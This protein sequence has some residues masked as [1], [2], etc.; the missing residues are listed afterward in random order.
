MSLM[1]PIRAHAARALGWLIV[2]V[3]LTVFCG[4]PGQGWANEKTGPRQI[5][6]FI[7]IAL[8][9]DGQTYK[10]TRQIVHNAIDKAA[11]QNARLTLI[12]QFDVPKGEKNFGRG[13][14]FG[15]AHDLADF[16]S[17]DELNGV[18][19]VAYLPQSIEGH[20][21]LVAIACQ[22][23]MMAPDATIGAAGI[24]EST[25]GATLR[26]AYTEVA[27]RRRTVPA[28][29]ALG[30]LDPAIEVLQVDT[31][32][33]SE[34]VTPEGLEKVQKEHATKEPIVI[35]RAGEQAEFS[36]SE[37][38][39][40]GIARYLASDRQSVA[41]ALELPLTAIG[42]DPSLEGGWRA[43][44]VD[45]KGPIRAES[46]GQV[47]RM[48]EKQVR[49]NGVNFIC[50]WIDSPGGPVDE[51]MNLA[52]F[53]A[54]QLDPAK[55]RTVAYVPREALSDA[56]IIAMSCDQLVMSPNAILGG[57]GAHELSADEVS[58]VRQVI[59]NRLAKHKGRSWSLVAAMIDPHLDVFRANRLGDIE[60]F[61][62]TELK[63]QADSA[64]WNRGGASDYA[65]RPAE[66]DRHACGRVRLGKSSC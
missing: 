18:R 23:I 66:V 33:G 56:A 16:L 64:K 47:E 27:N 14:E 25:I 8:P 65:R 37:A 41:K 48:I 49:D 1:L 5:G 43:V 24:D 62:E 61:S 58:Q 6:R 32:V 7:H 15:A 22:E 20:A 44:R 36:G 46:V 10:R 3:L 40:L 17:G 19:T 9:I 54:F 30:M 51:A 2:A 31:A 38:R 57:P 59:Q 55:V 28:A 42:N 29:L 13:S 12:F 60:Y 50:L 53:L 63:E 21:V 34:F 35:K 11:K 45:L 4:L 26:S 52:D 39:R